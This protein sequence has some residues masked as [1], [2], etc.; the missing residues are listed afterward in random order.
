MK[1]YTV[2]V[3]SKWLPLKVRTHLHSCAS[4]ASPVSPSSYEFTLPKLPRSEAFRRSVSGPASS[5]QVNDNDSKV[6]CTIVKKNDNKIRLNNSGI[7]V[8][9][10]VH[11]NSCTSKLVVKHQRQNHISKQV[12]SL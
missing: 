4:N 2:N 12:L 6:T 11:K 5:N 1:R 10:W 9:A 7:L 3:K 8:F